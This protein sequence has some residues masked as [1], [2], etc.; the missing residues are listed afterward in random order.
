MKPSLVF[1]F[2]A[3]SPIL[4]T[5]Q[6]QERDVRTLLQDSAYV[7]NRFE[8]ATTGLAIQI[9]NW[10]VP[11]SAKKG[12]KD[13]L[14]GALRNVRAEKPSLNA[15][16]LKGNVSTTDLYDVYSELTE[17]VMELNDQSSNF[18]NWG[19]STKAVELAQL[20]AKTSSLAANV[21]VVLRGKIEA[22]EAQLT[23]CSAKLTP[24]TAKHK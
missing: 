12:F 16:L 21:G 10:S 24:P 7:F 14:S 15:L 4:A 8:E 5:A 3:V 1:F 9:D 11:E 20:G 22:Q 18:A 19:D 13:E 2:L 17:V 6:S 23:A